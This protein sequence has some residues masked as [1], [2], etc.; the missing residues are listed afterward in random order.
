MHKFKKYTSKVAT[1]YTNYNEMKVNKKILRFTGLKLQMSL[2]Y[3]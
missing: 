3:V 2:L 1:L